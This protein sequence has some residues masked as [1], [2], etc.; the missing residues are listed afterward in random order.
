M[1][2]SWGRTL[3][4][5]A[6]V[7]LLC[8]EHMHQGT[9]LEPLFGKQISAQVVGAT[10]VEHRGQQSKADV[11]DADWTDPCAC[12]DGGAMGRVGTPQILLDMFEVCFSTLVSEW[13]ELDIGWK[14]RNCADETAEP[15]ISHQFFADGISL[16]AV[17]D[18]MV[19]SIC[20]GVTRV[21]DSIGGDCTYMQ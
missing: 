12:A 9:A 13:D 4:G 1:S 7:I 16:Y 18:H 15:P 3:R 17:D 11:R 21:V 2:W 5:A 19:Q 6:G 14:F 20:A 8:S 10:G